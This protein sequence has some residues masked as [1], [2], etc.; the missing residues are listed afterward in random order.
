VAVVFDA[1]IGGASAN[2][3]SSVS[4]YNQYR[5]N[6]GFAV[7]DTA[8]AQVDLIRG[9][10]WLESN[11]RA[12]WLTNEKAEDTQALHWP[13]DGAKDATGEEIDDDVIPDQVKTA[14]W[15]YAIRVEAAEQ[16]SLDPVVAGNVKKQELDGL[17]SQEFFS[18]SKPGTLPDDFKFI[19]TIL[20]GLISSGSGGMRILR[21][22]RVG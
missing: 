14:L 1:T 10:S 20:Y 12:K 3:Y 6:H 2:S 7:R 5:E 15:E 21:L 4:D 16:T 9:T 8:D 22:E 11:Y 13:Q 18:Q 19:D 17:G